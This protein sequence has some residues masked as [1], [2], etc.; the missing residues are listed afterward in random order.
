MWGRVAAIVNRVARECLS[1]EVIQRRDLREAEAA[2]PVGF[3]EDEHSK[4]LLDK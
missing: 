3:W 1:D 4:H 2:S